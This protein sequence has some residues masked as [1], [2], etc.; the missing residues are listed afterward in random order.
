[1]KYQ[2]AKALLDYLERFETET[3][4]S[5][6]LAFSSW[7]HE[8][9]HPQKKNG[10][11][12]SE[13]TNTEGLTPNDRIAAGI[14]MLYQHSRHYVKAALQDSPLV[15]L[16]DFTF[17]F[18]LLQRG[19]MRKK[20]LI[21]QAYVDFSPGMEVIRRLLRKE[22]I[23]EFDDPDDGRSRRVR[24]S[25]RGKEVL[26]QV[27]P[28]MRKASRLVAGPLAPEEKI[29]FFNYVSKLMHFHHS[30]WTESKGNEL[31]DLIDQYLN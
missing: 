3:G 7:L 4:Q 18:R 26:E 9:L 1:M 5:D 29:L 27:L 21:D 8:Q 13:K 10:N 12:F 30:I 23:T 31:D 6:M 25:S 11:G 2:T 24:L 19:D 22:L 14:S 16:H 28:K 20:E 15:S 17:L